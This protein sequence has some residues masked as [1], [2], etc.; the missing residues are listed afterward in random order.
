MLNQSKIAILIAAKFHKEETESPKNYL[1][2]LGANVEL[3]GLEKEEVED[4]NGAFR[5]VPDKTFKDVNPNEYD[6][7]I[8]P[9]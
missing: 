7:V 8:I 5:I 1:S 4:K 6:C 9:G 3:I 2:N